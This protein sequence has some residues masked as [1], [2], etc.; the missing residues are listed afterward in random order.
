MSDDH[1]PYPKDE[2]TQR[3]RIELWAIVIIAAVVIV[4]SLAWRA[5]GHHP[6][7]K[8]PPWGSGQPMGAAALP[9]AAANNPAAAKPSAP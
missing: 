1:S 4:G 7:A 6:A 9:A 5:I 2:Q 8:E 3:S